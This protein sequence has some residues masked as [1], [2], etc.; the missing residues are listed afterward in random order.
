M[1]IMESLPPR[2]I[3]G[4]PGSPNAKCDLMRKYKKNQRSAKSRRR[5]VVKRRDFRITSRVNLKVLRISFLQC[6]L[7]AA[8][9]GLK[10]KDTRRVRKSGAFKPPTSSMEDENSTILEI[11]RDRSFA[12]SAS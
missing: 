10:L 1:S 7:T 4:E 11:S 5:R 3:A 2:G 6:G 8:E 9:I 12:D